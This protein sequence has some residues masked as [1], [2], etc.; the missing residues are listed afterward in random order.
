MLKK[1]SKTEITKEKLKGV[2][3]WQENIF[4]AI[5][6]LG[7]S[8]IISFSAIMVKIFCNIDLSSNKK[9]TSPKN[10]YR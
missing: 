3:S 6:Y 5:V 7:I 9:D 10:L 8:T 2:A 1:T 4:L